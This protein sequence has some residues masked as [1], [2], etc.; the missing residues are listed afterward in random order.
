MCRC[1]VAPSADVRS[2][3]RLTAGLAAL[4]CGLLLAGCAG[5]PRR[6]P[7]ASAVPGTTTTTT[8]TVRPG[9]TL[10]GIARRFGVDYHELARRN[11]LGPDYAIS[12]GQRLV[13]TPA[14]AGPGAPAALAAAPAVPPTFGWPVA[15]AVGGV[16]S[17]PAGGFG[18]AIRAPR[19]SVVRAAAA[20]R[21]VYRGQGLRAYGLL[22]IVR[23]DE[24]YLSAYAH[25]A[26]AAVGEGDVCTGGM[27][28]G[29]VGSTPEGDDELYFEIRKDGKPVDPTGLLPPRN[30]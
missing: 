30:P 9:D 18:L 24:H 16:V 26:D 3:A 28:L 8:Y 1:S 25:L 23:H 22:V 14:P 6:V 13:V 12:V 29:H 17:R 11:G 2:P 5:E 15:G 10:Y 4:A 19:G 7:P 21:V 20:G 27:P